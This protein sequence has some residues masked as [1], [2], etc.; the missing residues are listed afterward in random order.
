MDAGHI[1]SPAVHDAP[2]IVVFPET[3]GLRLHA[4]PTQSGGASQAWFCDVAGVAVADLAALLHAPAGRPATPLF[5]P[6]LAGE[7][8]PLWN[9]ALRGAFLGLSA[10]MGTADL[11]RAVLEG[12]ALSAR[13]VLGA[14]QAS[15]GGTGDTILCGGGGFA[16]DAWG[17]IR[18]DVLNRR[19]RRLAANDPVV[20]GATA[21]AAVGAGVHASFAGAQAALA[22]Y[23][24]EWLPNP[25]NRGLY[26]DLFGIYLEAITVN[27]AI[28]RRLSRL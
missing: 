6:Q 4:G 9:A 23:D 14:V 27:E 13:H 8:A 21:L 17:Q 11:A 2:G 15:A 19:L 1:C 3:G 28:G 22:R 18:A 20:I 25:A 7:R 26:D 24:T 16:S 5:L 10:G 12:V